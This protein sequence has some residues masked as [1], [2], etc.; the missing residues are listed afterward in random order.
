MPVAFESVLSESP[1]D[2]TDSPVDAESTLETG[3][4]V[5]FRLLCAVGFN[6]N[7]FVA[8]VGTVG[9]AKFNRLSEQKDCNSPILQPFA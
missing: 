7:Q 2:V 4:N 8:V 5:D 1:L 3:V 9:Y 6:N